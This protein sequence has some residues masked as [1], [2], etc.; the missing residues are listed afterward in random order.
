MK[1][2]IQRFDFSLCKA[3]GKIEYKEKTM[4][5]SEMRAR[6]KRPRPYQEKRCNMTSLGND[7]IIYTIDGIATL[8][9]LVQ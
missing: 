3:V 7:I 5:R 1:P 8:E 9:Y 2:Y 6:G 4:A